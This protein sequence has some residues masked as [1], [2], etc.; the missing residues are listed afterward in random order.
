MNAYGAPAANAGACLVECH[1][2]TFCLTPPPST[3]HPPSPTCP[4]SPN[5]LSPFYPNP[6]FLVLRQTHG[7]RRGGEGRGRGG[8]G[9][10]WGRRKGGGMGEDGVGVHAEG[11][12]PFV[13]RQPGATAAATA[14]AAQRGFLWESVQ[15]AALQGRQPRASLLKKRHDGN[16]TPRRIPNRRLCSFS[17]PSA[18]SCSRGHTYFCSACPPLR[19]SPLLC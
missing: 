19:F 12:R 3:L 13:Q 2:Q 4:L 11:S 7:W 8:G 16:H 15:R 1:F 14:A 5:P 6:P 17:F 18:P 10:G 9:R